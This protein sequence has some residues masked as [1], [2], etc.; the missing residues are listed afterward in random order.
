MSAVAT[1]VA[2]A[3]FA[4]APPPSGAE[5]PPVAA[6]FSCPLLSEAKDFDPP[7][8]WKTHRLADLGIQITLPRGWTIERD[9]RTAMAEA[10]DGQTWLSLR[11]GAPGDAAHLAR[12]QRDVEMTE[13]GPS[14]L[15]PGCAARV[16][17]RLRQL[18]GW[19]DLRLSV[20]RRALGQRRRAYALF[21]PLKDGTLTAVLTAKWRR[22]GATPLPRVRRLLRGRRAR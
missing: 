18:A 15:A 2:L 12:V 16:T 11:R 14:H 22:E 9:G 20:T 6:L 5:P 4:T 17:E 10:P 8:S 1:T 21:A 13:L 19:S 3:L 7:A